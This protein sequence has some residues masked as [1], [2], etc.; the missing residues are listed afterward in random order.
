MDVFINYF[1][2]FFFY[3]IIGWI[4]E[5]TYVSIKEK[6]VI[7]RGFLIGP[8]CPIYGYGALIMIIYLE[9]YKNNIFTVFILATVLCTTL[10][11]ITSYLMEKLFKA[12]WWD[13]SDKKFNLNGRV[14]GKNACLFG[15]GG[16]AVIYLAHPFFKQ[17]VKNMNKKLF[18]IINIIFL[19]IFIIDTIL[20]LNVVKHFKNTINAIDINKDATQ[21]F[22]KLV[23]ETLFTNNQILQKRLLS[24]F[25]NIDLKRFTKLK[26]N[27]LELKSYLTS[28]KNPQ[29]EQNNTKEK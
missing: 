5:S 20:S 23:K 11:Y 2:I 16:I 27:L 13:Y 3:S 15:L 14:C 18:L 17:L 19:I 4:V 6:K 26:E 12:R 25:P 10:E 8:Y 28:D 7:N 22:T 9:Q 29:N 24:A 1:S 21:D